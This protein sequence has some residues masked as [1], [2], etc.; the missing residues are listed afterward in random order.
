M[1]RHAGMCL[2]TMGREMSTCVRVGMLCVLVPLA[3]WPSVKMMCSTW[4][5]C[6]SGYFFAHLPLTERLSLQNSPSS[7]GHSWAIEFYM[8]RRSMSFSVNDTIQIHHTDEN[9]KEQSSE[10]WVDE[11][12]NGMQAS[13]AFTSRSKG[14]CR[15]PSTSATLWL[16]LCSHLL[17]ARAM[18]L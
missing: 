9:A 12:D 5:H 13:L 16:C 18:F 11:S 17:N 14:R 8:E 2:T 1:D 15:F 7:C 3:S 4:L 10:S 6:F